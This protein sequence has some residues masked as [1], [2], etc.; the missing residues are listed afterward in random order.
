V[1]R[2]EEVQAEG[3]EKV[4]PEA[5]MIA[6]GQNLERL[7]SFGAKGPRRPAQVVS[8]RRPEADRPVFREV[9]REHRGRCV[10]PQRYFLNTLAYSTHLVE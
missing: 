6:S 3:L 2:R 10:R 9:L 8:L 7:L 1:A 5:L 4:N